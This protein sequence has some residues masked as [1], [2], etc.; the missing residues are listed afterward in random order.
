MTGVNRDCGIVFQVLLFP[1]LKVLD[2]IAF[3]PLLERTTLLQR[4]LYPR[5]SLPGGGSLSRRRGNMSSVL[6]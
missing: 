5:L 6:G 3:G 2:N 1:H 4:V